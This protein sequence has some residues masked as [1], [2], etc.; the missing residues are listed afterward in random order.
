MNYFKYIFVFTEGEE[1]LLDDSIY[2]VIECLNKEGIS[3]V[4][5]GYTES[6]DQM[7]FMENWAKHTKNGGFIYYLAS[8]EEEL[9]KIFIDSGFLAKPPYCYTE[10]YADIKTEQ[11]MASMLKPKMRKDG[12]AWNNEV[13]VDLEIDG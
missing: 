10:S 7:V 8:V 13:M 11:S 3:L 4:F 9:D 12:T 5:F 1:F 2:E 6:T